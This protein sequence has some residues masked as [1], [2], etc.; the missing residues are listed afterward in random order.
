MIKQSLG[1]PICVLCLSAVSVAPMS[2][3]APPQTQP[4]PH[5]LLTPFTELEGTWVGSADSDHE[6]HM[7]NIEVTYHTT[8]AGS[9]VVETL[10]GGTDHEMV[11]IYHLDGEKLMMTHYCALG[12][13]PR[14]NGIPTRKPG[15][16]SFTYVNGTSI[17]SEDEP[18]MHHV[19]FQFVDKDH[20][21]TT[22]T[23]HT[24]GQPAGSTRL[25]L[26]RKQ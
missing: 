13:Q 15:L 9:A 23:M 1:W 19:S 24:N 18:H 12:N 21:Q 7:E 26:R 4:K 25:E 22:W 5:T 8:A 17:Q 10:F 6:G 14:M 11:S 20:I 2:L 3:A 16:Y